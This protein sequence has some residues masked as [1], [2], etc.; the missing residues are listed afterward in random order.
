MEHHN[1]IAVVIPCF[2]VK[3]HILDVINGIGQKLP[4]FMPLTIVVL[5]SLEI[6]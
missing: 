5:K 1:V 3:K 4:R 2:K 6:L